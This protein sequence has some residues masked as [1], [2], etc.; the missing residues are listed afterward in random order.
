MVERPKI[1]WLFERNVFEDRN[2][3]AMAEIVRSKGM[4]Y[5]EVAFDCVGGD[6]QHLRPAK[7]VPFADDDV[8]MAYGSMNLMRWLRRQRKWSKLAW[9]D[10]DRLRCQSYYAQWGRF[11][12]QQEYTFLP[13][14]EI[15]RRREWLFQTF[16]QNGRI[17]VRPDDNAKSFGGGIVEADG[18]GKWWDL[19]NFYRPGPDCLAV[20]ARPQTILAEWRLVIGRRKVVTGSQYRRSGTEEV[21]KGFPA[22]A[23]VFA[24]VV[25]SSTEFDPHPVYVMDVCQTSEGYRL[26]EIGSVCCASLYAC[27][28]ELMI[29]AVE[30]AAVT[31]A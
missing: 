26:V 11:L 16:G 22:E 8:V 12:L 9:Y 4:A 7:T 30:D 28:L 1:K 25:A 31:A 18:F 15:H 13:L 3:E 21:S 6:E 19:A 29:A 14:A 27:E 5:A 2:P 24:E 20:V 23:G 10:F 17:F